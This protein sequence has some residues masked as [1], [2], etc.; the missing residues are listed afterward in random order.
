MKYIILIF[1]FNIYL[2]ASSFSVTS[3]LYLKET[4]IN[5]TLNDIKTKTFENSKTDNFGF[6]QFSIWKKFKVKNETNKNQIFYAI[7]YRTILDFVDIY[8]I[9]EDKSI[10]KFLIGDRRAQNNEFF[11]SRFLLFPIDLKSQEEVE[12]YIS[13][14]NIRGIVETRWEIHNQKDISSIIYYDSLYF[15][16]LFGIMFLLVIQSFIFY[17]TLKEKFILYY[18]LIAVSLIISQLLFNGLIYSFNIGIPLEW[19][20]KPEI[21]F[22]FVMFFI[23]LFHYDYFEIKFENKYTRGFIKFLLLLPIF[24]ILIDIFISDENAFKL[25]ILSIIIHWLITIY[26]IAIGIKMSIKGIQGGWFYVS[27]QTISFLTSFLVFSYLIM[28]SNAAPPW[29]F[30]ITLMGGFINLIFLSLALFIRIKKRQEESKKKS[31]VLFELSKFHNSEMAMNNIIHQWKIPLTRIIAILTDIQAQVYLKKPI[32]NVIEEEL[33]EINKNATL[34]VNIVQEFY[35][36]NQKNEKIIFSFEDE[37]TDVL[38]MFAKKIEECNALINFN[39]QD[40]DEIL[41]TNR[42]AI[43]NITTIIVNN[44]LDAAIKRKIKHPI[45]NISIKK[46]YPNQNI[47]FEDNCGGVDYLVFDKVF[48]P[49]KSLSNNEARGLGLYIAKTLVEEKLE[50]NVKG[51]NTKH[52][53]TF[54]INYK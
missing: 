13:H 16:I 34:L 17:F 41:N 25:I 54:E 36:F 8:V 15:G 51:Y 44:F 53:A 1:F 43:S 4:N 12:I 37:L 29:I 5:L 30:Y 3:P 14:H 20:G 39:S 35:R 19:I 32:E 33:P 50:G 23:I 26:L 42:F 24:F 7:N 9:H 27:G 6:G 52:G 22:Y 11:E 40:K 38:K 47:K 49:F 45:L 2:F 48:E 46:K 10:D 18:G 28:T 31:E 21:P